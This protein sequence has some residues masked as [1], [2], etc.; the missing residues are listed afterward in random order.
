MGP[1]CRGPLVYL[2]S[3]NSK[4][5]TVED[6]T[7]VPYYSL[8]PGAITL[9]ELPEPYRNLGHSNRGFKNLN[10]NENQYG[11]LSQHA[12]KRLRKTIDYMLYLTNSKKITGTQIISKSNNI[13]IEYE[14]GQKFSKSVN[15]KLTFI[16]LTLPSPQI[17]TD[18]EIKS[19]CLNHFLTV[20]RNKYSVDLYIWK[21]EK[22]E[23]NNI[24]FHIL[25]NRFIKWQELRNEWNNIINKLGYVDRY[26]AKMKEFFKDGFRM[27][28]NSQDKRPEAAQR[29]AY[30]QNL[31]TGFTNPNSTDIHALYKIKNVAAYISK[32]IS[33]EVTKTDRIIK[34]DTIKYQINNINEQYT[35]LYNEKSN[36][37]TF[38][39]EYATI[40][41]QMHELEIQEFELKNQLQNLKSQGI[42]GRIWGCSSVL[43]QCKNYT[44]LSPGDQIPD[45]EL[46]NQIKTGEYITDVGSRKIVTLTFDINKT[47]ALNKLLH[48]HILTSISNKEK[49]KL[50]PT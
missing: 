25:T 22:Q 14:K 18:N 45:I 41:N 31:L 20:L 19:T 30:Y 35:A 11:E 49:F 39:N 33:K 28:E 46:I 34:I 29:S 16:T 32:Y 12:T 15:Y 5:F 7:F 27:S 1:L 26:Q 44:D 48:D 37:L 38:S 50:Q 42:Q 23:N 21:A 47:P 8:K 43:S 13:T 4:T 2:Q 40:K 36:Y 17:H 3:H 24:H 6:I 9:Y 10:N